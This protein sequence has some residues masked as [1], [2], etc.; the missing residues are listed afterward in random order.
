MPLANTAPSTIAEAE[1]LIQAGL[2]RL[3]DAPLNDVITSA[4]AFLAPKGYR[5][6][7]QMEEEGRKKRSTASIS[8][9][10][11]ATGEIVLFFEPVNAD[12]AA[13]PAKAPASASSPVHAAGD[14]SSAV[15]TS[16]HTMGAT[17][18][19]QANAAPA[20]PAAHA[21]PPSPMVK[22]SAQDEVRECCEALAEAEKLGRPFYAIKWFR[23]IFLPER[24]L[25]W[26]ASI[27]DRQ[28]VLNRTIQGGYIETRSIPNPN[29]AAFPTTTLQ[30]NREKA[31]TLSGARIPII[32]ATDAVDAKEETAPEI[33]HPETVTS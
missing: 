22:I 27:Q 30:L 17:A 20:L 4:L 1:A 26:A 28:R 2:E 31:A 29:N 10:N 25:S 8:N 12:A 6:V 13:T 14:A 33:P 15:S 11:H 16:V 18:G 24:E 21:A 5:V 3:R 32:P 19:G 7:A 23:D 9:W